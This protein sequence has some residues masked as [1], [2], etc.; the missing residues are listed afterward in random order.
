[1]TALEPRISAHAWSA[2]ACSRRFLLRS[3]DPPL[4]AA[5]GRTVTGL[6]RTGKRLFIALDV[7]L[8]PVIH[9]MIAGRLYWKAAGAKPPAR[10][11][12]PPS[13]SRPAPVM[14]GRHEKARC[15]TRAARRSPPT[16]PAASSRAS[17]L[18]AF[19]EGG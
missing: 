10:S 12:S 19:R 11:D 13:I 5:A 4:S 7:E 2:C 3:V 14:T 6:R 9:I 17:G 15:S 1:L 16:T 18:A 8:F